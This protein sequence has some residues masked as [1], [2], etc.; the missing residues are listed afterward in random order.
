LIV[1]DWRGRIAYHLRSRDGIHWK[2]DP[3]AA[4]R[5]G[6]AVYEGGTKVDWYKYERPKVLQDKYGRATQMHFAVI[7]VAKGQ[8]KGKD[9]H[10]SKHIC[11]PMT[12]GRL[13]TILD[14]ERIHAETKTIRVRIAAEE[15]FNSHTD[16][17]V[18]SLR[19]GVPEQV[20]FGRGCKAVKTE[21]SGADLIVTFAGAGNGITEDNF[22]AKLLGKTSGGKLLFGY[23]R[24]PGLN[25]LE[26]ALSVLPPTIAKK[27]D[28]FKIAVEVQ[29]FG[30]VAST[31]APLRI[32]YNT[33]G[34]E[35]EVA[36][37]KVPA[38]GPF[39]KT[40]V[41][42]TCGN[43]FEPGVSYKTSMIIHPDGQRPVTLQT[44]L[45]PPKETK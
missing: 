11:I 5:P 42:F 15:G 9:D 20:D 25:Y 8:D 26:P 22:T 12:V 3:G 10:S 23:A 41:E 27:E 4:Y 14:K 21:R 19:L 31:P 32:V 24:L 1:N 34:R 39:E 6:I 40:V 45:N 2:V 13:V 18:D 35:V 17:D 16:L 44:S 30:Q 43:I 7:D 36:S 29:N 28:G 37:G 33:D 38:L